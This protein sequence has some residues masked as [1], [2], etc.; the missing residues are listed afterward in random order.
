VRKIL[1]VVA[2]VVVIAIAIVAALMFTTAPRF[3]RAV[4]LI[5]RVPAS[6]E[7][8]AI[9]PNAGVLDAKA[10][11][12]PITRAALEKWSAGHRL[13]PAWMLG[14]GDLIVW[15]SG[16]EV[17]YIAHTDRLRAMFVHNAPDEPPL[18]AA[19]A[20]Q[21]RALAAR[22]PAGDALVVQRESGHGAYPPIDRPTATSVQIT[23][24]EIVLTSVGRSSVPP[25]GAKSVP[26]LSFPRGAILSAAFTQ[27]PRVVSDLNRLFGAK[28]SALFDEGGMICI[29][30]VDAHK[31]LPRPLGVIV[32]PDDPVRRAIVDR[33]KQAEAVGI[34]V[35]TA[36]VGNTIAVA[37]DDSIDQYQKDAF[38]P[39]PEAKQWSV[40]IDAPRLVPILNDLQQ[41][42]GLRLAAPRLFRSTRDLDA[43]LGEL[44]QA[45]SIEAT[46]SADSQVE[47]LQARIRAK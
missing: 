33:F 13:P 34:R 41:N 26:H 23:P 45:K 43:W 4:D 31:L 39:A 24:G 36:V 29:Y 7:V 42:I 11:L 6:A 20:A 22:L 15:K 10:H 12:N 27:P 32:L 38:D 14:S 16:G 5:A 25:D 30:D 28:V 17:R 9:I 3:A 35:R 2:I 8:F 19:T 18:D 44:E 1:I 46:D 40:R 37:F 21:L 47:T